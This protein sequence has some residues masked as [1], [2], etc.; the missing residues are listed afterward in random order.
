MRQA[1]SITG[2]DLSMFDWFGEPRCPASSGLKARGG[3]MW[4]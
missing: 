1:Y 4:P 3:W 2:L